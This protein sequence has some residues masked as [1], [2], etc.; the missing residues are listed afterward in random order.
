MGTKQKLYRR[1]GHVNIDARDVARLLAQELISMVELSDELRFAP[2]RKEMLS[3]LEE[4][5]QL[6]QK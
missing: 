6:L 2:E 5:K 3:K 1:A 4:I